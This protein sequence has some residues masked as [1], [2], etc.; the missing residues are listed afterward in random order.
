[1]IKEYLAENTPIRKQ[2]FIIAIPVMI[3]M[4]SEYILN[5]TDTAFIGHYDVKGLSAITNAL[6]PYFILLSLFFATSKGVTIL[7]AQSIG[8]NQKKEAR[9]YGESS[10][11]FNQIISISY[12]LFYLFLGRQ[13]LSLIGSTEEILELSHQYISIISYQFLFFGLVLSANAIFEGKGITLPI[14]IVSII[15][16]CK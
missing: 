3:Q 10:F 1:M 12:F 7:I 4:L 5:L 16:Y 14:M 6:Y 8:A 11:L 15:I 2:I 13:F 9:R